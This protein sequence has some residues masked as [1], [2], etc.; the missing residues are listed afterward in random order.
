[1]Q[2]P[3]L[4]N[5]WGE[6]LRIL[7]GMNPKTIAQYQGYIRE[8]F[9]WSQ[10]AMAAP[11]PISEVTRQDIEA[12][13][14]HLFYKKDNNNYTRKTKLSC[15]RNFWRFLIYEGILHED[16]TVQ[17]PVPIVRQKL[18][19][20]FTQQEVLRMFAKSD[21]YSEQ[22]LRDLCILIILA[23][24][25]LRVAELCGLK[26]NDI[27]DDGEYI[28]IQVNEE[29]GKKGSTRVVDLWKA[30]S[31]IVREWYNLRISHGASAAS[32]FLAPYR[33][34]MLS[35]GNVH[36]LPRQIDRIVKSFADRASVRK[37]KVTTHMFRATHASDLRCIA[38]YDIAA[39]AQRLGHKN[40]SV[41][42]RYMPRRGRIKK[43]YRSLREY[44]IDFEKIWMEKGPADDESGCV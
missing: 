13:L 1:M 38:G 25:G 9:A 14:E 27:R 10:E 31:A 39:I 41:T 16:I 29:I 2:L 21:P 36:I 42:D 7:R 37:A 6:H 17:I 44:W 8:F 15:I 12:Y 26:L 11:K 28:D 4:L 24:C 5:K 20:A 40:I 30:P 3:E 34:D 32:P 43:Q 33:N 23:F 35:D 18:I 19:Q 22:G